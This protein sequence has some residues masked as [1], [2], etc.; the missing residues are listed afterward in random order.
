MRNKQWPVERMQTVVTFLRRQK[1]TVLQ[2][3]LPSEPLLEDVV[4]LR[5]KTSLRETAA[6]LQQSRLF[7]GLVGFQMH[8]ARAVDCPSVII[9]GGRETP[10]LTGYSCNSNVTNSPSCSPCW[11]RSSCSFRNQC[12][13]DIGVSTVTAAV[14]QKLAEARSPLSEDTWRL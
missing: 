2:I 5:G 8:L 9:Y 14:E 1:H 7:I 4:D 11:L 6:V 3:G 12:M 13:N 10:A